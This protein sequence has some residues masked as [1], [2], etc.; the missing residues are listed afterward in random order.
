MGRIAAILS[1]F[2]GTLCPT[3]DIRSGCNDWDLIP[4]PLE[5]ILSKISLAIPISIVTS[6]DFDFI[7]PKTKKFAKILSCILGLETFVIDSKEQINQDKN[8]LNKDFD[9]EMLENNSV[10]LTDTT[11]YL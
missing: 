10:I 1:D 7:Y 11:V 8:F 2:D 6:K 3:S 5:A 4:L 9:Y